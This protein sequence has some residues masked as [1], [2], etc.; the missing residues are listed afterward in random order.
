M[1]AKLRGR[2]AAALITLLSAGVALGGTAIA[3]LVSQ[4][5]AG[6]TSVVPKLTRAHSNLPTETA[7]AGLTEAERRGIEDTVR[8][9]L[10]AIAAGDAMRAFAKLAPSTQHYFTKPARY[11]EALASKLPPILAARHFV[12]LG[13]GRDGIG[14]NQLVL[15]TDT[16]G[17]DWLAR[18]R[19][20][21]QPAGDWRVKDCVV[22]AVAGE[23]V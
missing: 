8:A 14:V 10:A 23:Q 6:G 11:L 17:N 20:E 22:G 12:F 21:R 1:Q 16:D 4:F 2:L 15:I 13:A 3:S 5:S 18:F 9:Q 7:S 19:V